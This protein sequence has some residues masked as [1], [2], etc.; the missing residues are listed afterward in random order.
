MRFPPTIKFNKTQADTIYISS[1][2]DTGTD[3]ELPAVGWSCMQ[4]GHGGGKPVRK[5]MCESECK[6]AEGRQAHTHLHVTHTPWCHMISV[7]TFPHPESKLRQQRDRL[8]GVS[9]RTLSCA[10]TLHWKH[11]LV[12]SRSR[13]ISGRAF[14]NLT[15][16][17]L[18]HLTR[19]RP[20]HP[21]AH[22]LSFI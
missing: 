7:V 9:L 12:K 22:P 3:H 6:S 10:D 4:H 20:A 2:C 19:H 8:G 14:K 21:T 11:T 17:T 13:S 5:K 1:E 15:F 18:S 16:P